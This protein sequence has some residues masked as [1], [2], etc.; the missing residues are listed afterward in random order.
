MIGMNK[1]RLLKVIAAVLLT[2]GLGEI[3]LRLLIHQSN[4]PSTYYALRVDNR[5]ESDDPV[6]ADHFISML[7]H[8]N[9][10]IEIL[11]FGDSFT[12][13]GNVLLN[14]TYPIK[15]WK[16]LRQKYTVRNLAACE[17]ST[18]DTLQILKHFIQGPDFDPQKK[19]LSFFLVGATDQF[20]DLKTGLKLYQSQHE[21]IFPALEYQAKHKWIDSFYFIKALTLLKDELILRS[22]LTQLKN[23]TSF[24]H[25]TET[26]LIDKDTSALT[27][28]LS[29]AFLA[30]KEIPEARKVFIMFS[31]MKAHLNFSSSLGRARLIEEKLKIAERFPTILNDSD[32][33]WMILGLI[34]TQQKLNTEDIVNRL[35]TISSNLESEIHAINLN[36]LDNFLLFNTTKLYQEE[37]EKIWTEMAQVLE[38]IDSEVIILGYPLEYRFIND[39]LFAVAYQHH[40]H[41]INLE[42]IFAQAPKVDTLIDDWEHASTQGHETIAQA[43]YDFLLTKLSSSQNSK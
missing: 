26:C 11:T 38:S 7:G 31:L 37:N 6:H 17:A 16:K 4:L 22:G 2:L 40:F 35:K 12:N 28:C 21:I 18:K 39:F 27:D 34:P 1:K 20:H 15:L 41:F 10:E 36:Y 3:S 14:H 13:G 33:L 24:H 9:Q 5:A 25:A 8:E 42:K 43:V 23:V 19:Y 29:E 30:E 32:H